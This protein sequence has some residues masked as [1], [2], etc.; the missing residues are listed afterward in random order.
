MKKINYFFLAL[1]LLLSVG[2]AAQQLPD[3]HFE[4]WSD[5]FDGNVQPKDWHGSNV[6]QMGFK[7][8]FLY[9]RDGRSGKCAYV[10]NQEVGAMGVTETAPGYFSL[11]HAWSAIEGIDTKTG[12][13]GTEGGIDF[14]Y[15]PDTLSVWI[16]RTGGSATNEDFNI[17][18]YSWQG[19]SK[20]VSYRSKG[21]SCKGS[22][23]TN[24]ECDIRQTTNGN[25]CGTSVYA[26]QVAEGWHRER[27][28]YDSWTNIR[29]PIYYLRDD[30]PDKIN[31]IF[32]AG[33]APN[34]FSNAGI[35]KGN[36]LYVDDVELIYSCKIQKI[37]I[38][39]VAWNGFNPD[40]EEEQVYSLGQNA[41]VVPE[42]YAMR[43]AGSLTNTQSKTADFPGRRLQSDEITVTKG[44][45]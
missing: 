45:V 31:V 25:T 23:H 8:T 1:L 22:N 14:K 26:K 33:N 37:F 44:A 30:A 19:E 15:R 18:F 11:G 32:S 21:G 40:T 17:V 20:G 28:K 16:K 35:T 13:G 29:V 2:V 3:P 34:A 39:G 38:D 41:T 12:T 43:G 4:D 36:D 9:Q 10:T 42:I 27:A 6:S 7:F 24:E 5:S